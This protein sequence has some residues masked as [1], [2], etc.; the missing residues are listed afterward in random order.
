MHLRIRELLAPLDMHIKRDYT[1]SHAVLMT[2]MYGITM[3]CYYKAEIT[4]YRTGIA[5]YIV[6]PTILFLK[7]PL[8][9][10]RVYTYNLKSIDT[11]LSLLLIEL[12]NFQL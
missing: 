5:I 9:T 3:F 2:A 11:Y 6:I 1:R 8:S 10:G 7:C 4:I 12:T